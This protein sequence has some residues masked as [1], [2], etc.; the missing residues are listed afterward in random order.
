MPRDDEIFAANSGQDHISSRGPAVLTS[1][2]L[3]F[4]TNV[5]ISL[6]PTAVAE[7]EVLTGPAARLLGLCREVGFDI[8]AHPASML[9]LQND[10]DRSR[11]EVRKLLLLK[12]PQL[13][14]PPAPQKRLK[15][16]LGTPDPASNDGVDH[17]MI[18][19]VY[20][21]AVDF[22]VTEDRKLHGKAARLGIPDRILTVEEALSLVGDFT[23]RHIAPPPAVRA[24]KAHHIDPTEPILASFR[25]D[26]PGFDE[27][28]SK[29]RRQ[30]RQAWII[31]G[32]DECLAG[33]CIVNRE[34]DP[35]RETSGK[36][37]KICSFKVS[38]QYNGF[39]FGELLLKSVFEYA[40]AHRYDWLFVT[41]FEKYSRLI[42]LFEAFGFARLPEETPLGELVL[43]KPLRPDVN[44]IPPEDPLLFHVRYGPPG[45]PNCGEAHRLL[46]PRDRGTVPEVSPRHP[47][48]PGPGALEANS[49]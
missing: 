35:P 31:N 2:K 28:F 9:D 32:V 14:T 25:E 4:D 5:L 6:E 3:L 39:R 16:L 1:L 30:H 10:K 27:W 44:G 41:T 47:L 42:E 45:L 18:A 19:A 26:Y 24:V 34:A 38:E 11:F 13:P 21:D 15:E 22:L 33:F 12:Y 40:H 43:A 17:S 37:L 29:C 49:T 36:V 20:G 46:T 23:S 8:F 48:S 7:T